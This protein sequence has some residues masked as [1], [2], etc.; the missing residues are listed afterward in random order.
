MK[1]LLAVSV[2]FALLTGA[3][4]AQLTFSGGVETG[5]QMRFGTAYEDPNSPQFTIRNFD[6]NGG[7]RLNLNGAFTHSSGTAGGN[8][9]L[10]VDYANGTNALQ[11]RQAWLWYQPMDMLRIHVGKLDGDGFGTGSRLDVS[12]DVGGSTGIHF[13][14]TPMDG[15]RVGLTLTNNNA[16][17]SSINTLD[18]RFGF[19]YTMAGTF[20]LAA[21]VALNDLANSTSGAAKPINM[22]FGLNVLALADMGITAL[23]VDAAMNNI[24]VDG[25]DPTINLGQRLTFAKDAISVTEELRID[26]I[27]NKATDFMSIRLHLNGSYK[28]DTITAGLAVGFGLN[29]MSG[30]DPRAWDGT[31]GAATEDYNT[32]VINPYVTFPLAGPNVTIGYG[33]NVGMPKDGDTVMNHAIYVNFS[34]G[35]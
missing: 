34:I 28:I 7:A 4:F 14:I 8:F 30:T 16:E 20:R 21:N 22:A 17:N 31:G 10:R 2:L 35:F 29:R 12:N 15:L 18:L 11:N 3:A 9:Q 32:L 23:S 19:V 24:G 6:V 27:T 25:V 1:K 33:A 26:D 5:V 13:R